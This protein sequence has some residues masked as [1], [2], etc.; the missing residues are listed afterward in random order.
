[1]N[2]TQEQVRDALRAVQ[3]PDLHRDIVSLGFVKDI[4]LENGRVG[5]TIE[6]T[7]PACPVK[8][9]MQAEAREILSGLPG[10][11][12]V[13]VT[14][15]ASV[16]TKKTLEK[17]SLPGV[18]N[19]LAVSACKGGVGKTTVSVN[20]AI[21]LRQTGASVGLMDADVYGPN[22]PL[23]L[24]LANQEPQV[25]N[26]KIIPYEA[27]GMKTISIGLILSDE[28]PLI[29]RGPM[30]HSAVTQFLRGWTGGN[31]TISSSTCRPAPA[32]PS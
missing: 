24:G 25:R 31:W 9:K 10:V 12:A 3:D 18:K 4:S 28:Q 1:M 6:L 8:E 26:E 29:W 14:M 5:V 19:I 30:V 20:L 11:S 16:T 22:V 32:M 15:T 23:M 2:L 21:A 17:Q 13:E 27:F 7:T